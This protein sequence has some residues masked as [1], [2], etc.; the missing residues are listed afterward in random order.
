MR[1]LF[2]LLFILLAGSMGIVGATKLGTAPGY[3]EL[4]ADVITG[5]AIPFVLLVVGLKLIRPKSKPEPSAA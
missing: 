2:G 4:L 5:F 1:I 3:P